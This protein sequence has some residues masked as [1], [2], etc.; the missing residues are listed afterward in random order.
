MVRAGPP[1][2]GLSTGSSREVIPYRDGT[3]KNLGESGA[4]GRA[5][6]GA[7][8]AVVGWPPHSAT[9]ILAAA[10]LGAGSVQT[11]TQNEGDDHE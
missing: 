10:K 1:C 11:S 2:R 4:P 8:G 3:V 6:C 9:A 5:A 7:A